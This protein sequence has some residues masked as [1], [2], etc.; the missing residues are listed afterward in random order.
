MKYYL[1][2]NFHL[3]VADGQINNQLGETVY[4]YENEFTFLPKVHLYREGE[5][6]GRVEKAWTFFMMKYDLYLHGKLVDSLTQKMKMFGSRLEFPQ[7]GWHVE[8]NFTGLNY[9]IYDEYGNLA[10]EVDQEILSLT[11]RFFI[12]IRQEEYEDLIILLV[13]AINQFDKDLNSRNNASV[14]IHI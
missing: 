2:E 1:K 13:I 6:I 9:S 7:L 3:L 14:H 11:Q 12:D 5:E 8:G 10:A 4:T